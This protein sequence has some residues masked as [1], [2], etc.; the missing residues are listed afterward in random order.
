[1]HTLQVRAL[2]AAGS[3]ITTTRHSTFEVD[4][5]A[6]TVASIVD[7]AGTP[8]SNKQNK[9]VFTFDDKNFDASSVDAS[10]FLVNGSYVAGTFAT[11]VVGNAVT[12]TFTPALDVPDSCNNSNSKRRSNP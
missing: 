6:P 8:G 5:K 12:L 3:V 10:D 9:V 1:M 2:N 11:S 7:V 4:T